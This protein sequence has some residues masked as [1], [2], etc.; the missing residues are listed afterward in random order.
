MV[1]PLNVYEPP[2]MISNNDVQTLTRS[3]FISVH[4][5]SCN[6]YMQRLT[7]QRHDVWRFVPPTL[8]L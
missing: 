2:I 3:T 1:L 7:S 8:S 6:N 5:R 4:V